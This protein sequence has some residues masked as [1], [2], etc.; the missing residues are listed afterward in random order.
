MSPAAAA[1]GPVP[2]A[3]G[4]ITAEVPGPRRR[5]GFPCAAA[6]GGAPAWT[7]V[8]RAALRATGRPFGAGQIHR[9]DPELLRWARRLAEREVGA[10]PNRPRDTGALVGGADATTTPPAPRPRPRW[11]RP[12]SRG[13][14]PPM[15]ARR[16][17]PALS[18]GV[19]KR[20]LR[21]VG[22]GE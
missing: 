9:D 15:A 4:G 17:L 20:N 18:P 3:R 19:R 12:P 5:P 14:R 7:P 22:A 1:P 6:G 2:R 16:P 21:G 10:A 8:E 11:A 13:V